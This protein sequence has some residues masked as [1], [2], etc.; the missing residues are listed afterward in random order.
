MDETLLPPRFQPPTSYEGVKPE[1]LDRDSTV[2][3]ICDF[4]GVYAVR[5]RGMSAYD[6][7]V[8]NHSWRLWQGLVADLHLVIAGVYSLAFDL[9]TPLNA[10]H[11]GLSDQSMVRSTYPVKDAP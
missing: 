9:S 11:G 8:S 3:D 6:N 10:S 5:R 2:D 1:P 4:Y 7:V